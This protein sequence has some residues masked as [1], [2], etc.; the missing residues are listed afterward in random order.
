MIDIDPADFHA[1]ANR[2]KVFA[3]RGVTPWFM[4]TTKPAYRGWFER[5]FIDG[6]YRHWWNGHYWASAKGGAPHWR[7]VG[8]YPVWRGLTCMAFMRGRR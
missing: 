2:R 3:R 7:Q 6:L 4:G 5:V 1:D 8:A